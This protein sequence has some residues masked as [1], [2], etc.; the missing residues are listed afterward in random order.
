[1]YP[2]STGKYVCRMSMIY[3]LYTISYFFQSNKKKQISKYVPRLAY[4]SQD[5]VN[6]RGSITTVHCKKGYRFSHPQP[7]CH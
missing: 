6:I 1:M 3:L 2:L 5:I 4:E 7:V